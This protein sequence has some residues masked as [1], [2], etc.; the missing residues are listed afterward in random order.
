MAFNFENL[1]VYRKA[2]DFADIICDHAEQFERRYGF[3][4]VPYPSELAFLAMAHHALAESE[5]AREYLRQLT[6]VCEKPAL[7]ANVWAVGFLKEA[8]QRLA[9]PP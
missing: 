9:A 1:L 4:A 5:M 8:R 2:V 6:G 7:K 3:L